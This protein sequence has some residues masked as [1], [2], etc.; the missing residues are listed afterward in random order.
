MFSPPSITLFEYLC[1]VSNYSNIGERLQDKKRRAVDE[2]K[3]YFCRQE[4]S[5]LKILY[6]T[7][8]V[9]GY[10]SRVGIF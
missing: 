7:V 1:I 10:F 8:V 9:A 5:E 4:F 3:S 6:H 2:I